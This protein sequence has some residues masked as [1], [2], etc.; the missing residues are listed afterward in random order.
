MSSARR[1]RLSVSEIRQNPLVDTLGSPAAFAVAAL[2]GIAF[3]TVAI[4]QAVRY[5]RNSKDD[6]DS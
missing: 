1:S 5:F 3:L 2:S 4:W 6:D